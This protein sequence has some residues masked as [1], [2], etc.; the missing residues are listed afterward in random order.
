[1]SEVHV[2]TLRRDSYTQGCVI[3]HPPSLTHGGPSL[4]SYLLTSTQQL[5]AITNLANLGEAVDRNSRDWMLDQVDFIVE[6][7][8]DESVELSDEMRSNLLQLLL[9]IA[10]LNEQI[11]HQASLSH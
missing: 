7:I 10:N 11:R 2:M 3:D 6:T 4:D 5:D 8:G 1:M 9:A